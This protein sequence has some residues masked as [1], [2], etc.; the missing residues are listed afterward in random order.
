M[1]SARKALI[2]G[3]DPGITSA[4]SILDMHGNLISLVSKRDA[5]KGDVIKIISE[6][7]RPV[8]ISTDKNPLPRSVGKL[9][10]NL[11]VKP[12]YPE[13]SLSHAEKEELVRELEVK[14]KNR[15]EADA[16]AASIKAWKN[17]RELSI[18]VSNT[19][20]QLNL[21]DLFDAVLEK[22]LKKESYSIHEAVN[23]ALIEKYKI[24]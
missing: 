10:R 24:S 1:T 4:I 6:F 18:K 14:T 8:I 23:Q 21:T 7:G 16:L 19:L 5:R 22:L 11:G 3:Y 15:H 13:M 2:V 17:Y 9:A 20:R 12:F